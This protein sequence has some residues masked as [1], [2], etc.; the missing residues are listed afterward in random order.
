[1][2]KDY[3]IAQERHSIESSLSAFSWIMVTFAIIAL[4][5]WLVSYLAR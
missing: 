3:D 4:A 2:K 1:M 5:A